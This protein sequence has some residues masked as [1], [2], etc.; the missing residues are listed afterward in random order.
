M[1]W[2]MLVPNIPA[3]HALKMLFSGPG[4]SQT[5]RNTWVGW[6]S[7]GGYIM[8]SAG[9]MLSGRDG[10]TPDYDTAALVGVRF[11]DTGGGFVEFEL[12]RN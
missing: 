10:K 6:Y 7:A 9:V 3:L 11:E 4:Y 12:Y 5:Y 1:A 2:A 8:D